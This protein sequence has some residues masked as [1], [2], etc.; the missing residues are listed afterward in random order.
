M[1]E[2][3]TPEDAL[4]DLSFE[5]VRRHATAT[6][7]LHNV[8]GDQ[9]ISSHDLLLAA[10][11]A[12][13][14]NLPGYHCQ[15][16]VMGFYDHNPSA[17]AR[18]YSAGYRVGAG[19]SGLTGLSSAVSS[20][21]LLSYITRYTFFNRNPSP[22]AR[23][24]RAFSHSALG[25][26]LYSLLLSDMVQGVGF[27]ISLKWASDGAI[28][29]S[30]ACTAQGGIFQV[31]DLGGALW[32]IA[33]AYHTFSLL[34]LLK[35]PSILTTRVILGTGWTVILVL[36][37]VG[38]HVI[39]NVDRSGHFYGV[40]GAWCWIGPGYQ[41]EWFLFLYI[42]VFLAIVSSIVMYGVS[43]SIPEHA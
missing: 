22:I 11:K 24:I 23:G 25:A 6:C 34:F 15:H 37:I 28:R 5:K 1:P 13:P 8:K 12:N 29:H 35:K 17:Y 39:Q 2:L 16:C 42:W 38:P 4:R 31:G 20:F 40:L 9:H 27:S 10:Q 43:R 18:E 14:H 26:Y 3:C 7:G 41:L 21:L 32:S 30:V 19:L 36:P 33:I